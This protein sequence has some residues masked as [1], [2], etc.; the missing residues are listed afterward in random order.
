MLYGCTFA[1]EPPFLNQWFPV[2][3]LWLHQQMDHM[4]KLVTEVHRLAGRGPLNW[5]VLQV[6]MQVR[7]VTFYNP[8]YKS[9]ATEMIWF[10]EFYN[11]LK[12][13][14]FFRIMEG[15]RPDCVFYVVGDE[16][17]R[18]MYL[19]QHVCGI[20]LEL[21]RLAPTPPPTTVDWRLYDY[22][23]SNC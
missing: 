6:G 20:P 23:Q 13:V 14:E 3:E 11:E 17:I 16:L 10:I 21:M 19:D 2:R 22:G 12:K 8:A 5:E 7:N 1:V 4:K 9:R 18:D 15:T